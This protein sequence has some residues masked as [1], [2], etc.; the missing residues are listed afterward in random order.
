MRVPPGTQSGALFRIRG[1]GLPKAGVRGDAHVRLM[2]EVPA[3]LPEGAR[4]LVQQ[5]A[6]TLEDAAYP[7]RQAFREASREDEAGSASERKDA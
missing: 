5:L 7:R 4:A 3:A 6:G 1:K 2:V